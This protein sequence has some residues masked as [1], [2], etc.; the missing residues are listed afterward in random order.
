MKSFKINVS[1]E[2]GGLYFKF[3]HN[4]KDQGI[5]ALFGPIGSG[6]STIVNLFG[7]FNTDLNAKIS[8]N[9]YE[10]QGEKFVKPRLRPVSIMFQENRLIETMTV[11]DNLNFAEQKSKNKNIFKKPIDKNYIIKKLNLNNKLLKYPNN[12]STGEKQLVSLARTLLISSQLIILDEPTSSLD[13][14]LKT[15]ILGF[16]KEFNKKFKTP[17][18][19]ISHVLEDIVQI[20]NEIVLIDKGNFVI[21][22]K[23]SEIL[24]NK[25]FKN[26]FGKF[27]S[28]SILEGRV[29]SKELNFNLTKIEVEKQTLFL[30]GNFKNKG[31]EIRV[32]VRARDVIISKEKLNSI[33]SEN[34]FKGHVVEINQEKDTAFSEIL[35][36]IGFKNSFQYLRARITRY[37]AKKMRLKIKDEIYAYL[38]TVSFDRQAII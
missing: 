14:K 5:T 38:K 3:N 17:I 28:S 24:I 16:L 9:N 30:P 18:L 2:F 22:G 12:L 15:K 19:L 8:I 31:D 11:F 4:F 37:E 6:K 20:S 33:F 21:S 13:I 36:K 10:I 35:I 32:R 1:G 25:K 29:I 23:I 7:G 34:I 26:F 27:E